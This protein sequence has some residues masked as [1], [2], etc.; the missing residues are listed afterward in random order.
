MSQLTPEGPTSKYHHI[1][2]MVSH[3]NVGG[4][5]HSVT[6]VFSSLWPGQRG[7]GH[8]CLNSSF[9]EWGQIQPHWLAG[10][11]RV[12]LGKAK[13]EQRLGQQQVSPTAS[14]LT[15]TSKFYPCL[16]NEYDIQYD[17]S[18]RNFVHVFIAHSEVLLII[19]PPLLF[20][21]SCE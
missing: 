10:T 18:D 4:H 8:S 11:F 6:C 2:I 5:I 7:L 13:W 14:N 19:T 17:F 1:G 21:S 20:F 15:F 9:W 12:M 16:Q 3:V